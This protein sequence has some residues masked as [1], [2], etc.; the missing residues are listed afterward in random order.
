M[1]EDT[2]S[3]KEETET[4]KFKIEG[5]FSVRVTDA[6]AKKALIHSIKYDASHARNMVLILRAQLYE[7]QKT[8][9]R[10]K[11][12]YS[13]FTRDNLLR[14][15]VYGRKGGKFAHLVLDLINHYKNNALFLQLAK[16]SQRQLDSKTFYGVL[17]SIS[18]SFQQ[19]HTNLK[20]YLANPGAYAAK[21][22]N[23]GAPRPPKAK[24]LKTLSET[25]L[26]LD[27]EKW[28]LKEKIVDKKT[29]EKRY[30]IRI[31]CAHKNPV[32]VPVNWKKF[33]LPAGKSLRALNINVSNDAV[34]LNFSYGQM[35]SGVEPKTNNILPLKK[36]WAA[37]D[38]GMINVLSLFVDDENT[39]SLL[40]C[41]N[42]Y[43]NYNKQFNRHKAALDKKIAAQATRFKTVKR[44]DD[45]VKVAIK[46]SPLGESLKRTRTHLIECRNRYFSSEFDKLS[47]R[48]IHY[49]LNANVTDFV[50]SKNLSFLKT[51][52]EKSSLRSSTRQSF[53]HLPFGRLLN[54]IAQKCKLVGI[55][56]HFIDEAYT[57]KM[58]C[59]SAD[60]RKA[61]ALRLEKGRSL[62]T[63][64]CKGSRVKRGL[65]RDHGTG[66]LYHADLNGSVNHIKI[67]NND[68]DPSYLINHK[69]KICTPLRIKSDYSFCR[70]NAVMSE[71]K[72]YHCSEITA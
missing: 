58:S 41:G 13:I 7:Q 72:Q 54:L 6:K 15:A 56:I 14:E 33:P 39:R 67:A 19:F 48:V 10:A 21:F 55:T 30:F 53:Y 25:S 57:S 16:F 34:Y 17:K 71:S 38:V 28:S 51:S 32:L 8:C 29:K 23:P 36:K 65:Y 11:E 20:A 60:V 61:K 50:L 35:Q 63:N 22:G 5:V 9:E 37:G 68:C 43:K 62:L 4:P 26:A 45:T 3:K 69:E 2:V 44:G 24:G 40:L 49:L 47:R 31:K 66:L 59:F 52:D 42:A 18:S 70:L 64:D 27:G 46:H 1:K 12:L